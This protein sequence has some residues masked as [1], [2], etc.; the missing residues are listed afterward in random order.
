MK[1][2]TLRHPGALNLN[3]SLPSDIPH[4]EMTWLEI[5][6]HQMLEVRS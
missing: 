3:P 1:N 4:R 2:Y 5:P 6:A